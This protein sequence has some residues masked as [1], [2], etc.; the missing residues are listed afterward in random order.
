MPRASGRRPLPGG[1]ARP[2]GSPRIA[3]GAMPYGPVLEHCALR[4]RLPATRQR[5]EGRV[6]L[7]GGGIAGLTAYATLR[8]GGLA[9]DE[10]MVFGT[11]ADPA[12]AWSERAR[13]IR[14][15]RMRSESD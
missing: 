4:P 12:A 10:I 8:H 3:G 2:P 15:R 7:V 11:D 6:A 9:P 1:G 13:A 14:Q 5:R